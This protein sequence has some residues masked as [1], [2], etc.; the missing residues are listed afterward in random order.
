MLRHPDAASELAALSA[1]AFRTVI[2]D[3]QADPAE[4]RRILLCTGKIGHD[5]QA[6]RNRLNYA[7]TAILLLDQ[8]YPFPE[9]DILDT[10]AL[11]KNAQEL[12]WVQEEPANMGAHS[13]VRPRLRRL[14]G[15][16]LPVLSIKRQAAASPATGSAKAHQLEQRALLA[17]AF[18]SS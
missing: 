18:T 14:A 7:G 9:G 2:A 8:L 4:V 11:Y 12:V 15:E 1:P 6:E 17:L 5:L 3:K 13:F 16:R 10:L